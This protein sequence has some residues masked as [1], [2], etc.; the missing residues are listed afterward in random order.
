MKEEAIKMLKNKNASRRLNMLSQSKDE[1]SPIVKIIN[2]LVLRKLLNKVKKEDDDNI[3]RYEEYENKEK[4]RQFEEAKML[5]ELKYKL[6]EAKERKELE[7]EERKERR[8][9]ER[10]ERQERRQR[11]RDEEMYNRD[12]S[13]MGVSHRQQEDASQ[14]KAKFKAIMSSFAPGS[15]DALDYIQNPEKFEKNRKLKDTS[16]LI[17][18]IKNKAIAKLKKTQY[19]PQRTQSY[20]ER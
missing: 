15:T 11:I 7:K 16:G 18:K 5:E 14:N 19:K 1:T 4:E 17:Y 10:E 3:R 20:L 8:Q 6:A 9:D 13:K 2:M 12:L